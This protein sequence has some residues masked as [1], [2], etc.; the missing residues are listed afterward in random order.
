MPTQPARSAAISRAGTMNQRRLAIAHL[1]HTLRRRQLERRRRQLLAAHPRQRQ[2]EAR[3]LARRRPHLE[4]AAVQH[5]ILRARSR[6]R[7]RC[8]RSCAGAT[9]PPARTGRTPAA[10]RSAS[11]RRRS[12][13]RRSRPHPGR[14][15]RRPRSACPRR[16]RSRCPAGSRGCGGCD[17]RRPRPRSTRP[18]PPAGCRSLGCGERAHRLDRVV[19]QP[20]QVRRLGLHVDR[21]RVVAAH[22]EEVR[23]AATRTARPAV[24]SSSA[25]RAVA[26]GNVSRWS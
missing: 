7:A 12:P 26:G 20:H 14:C 22:L 10:P 6:A 21:T 13:A 8:R 24:C 16:G 9:G 2:P 1:I 17:G 15:R 11:C 4:P 5:R 23:R 19:D 18:A 3:A 25:V